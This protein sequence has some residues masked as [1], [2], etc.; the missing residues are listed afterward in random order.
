MSIHGRDY[1]TSQ[2]RGGGLTISLQYHP[3]NS[4]ALRISYAMNIDPSQRAVKQK[5]RKLGPEVTSS[6]RR[7]GAPP[8]RMI[9]NRGQVSRVASQSGSRQKEE[10][11][12]E[13]MRRFHRHKQGVT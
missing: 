8:W 11:Q 7:Y 3:R 1:A 2:I 9:D 6:Q 12:I 4:T 10:Q 13:S 5:I